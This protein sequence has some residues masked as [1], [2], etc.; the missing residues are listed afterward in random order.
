MRLPV[1]RAKLLASNCASGFAFDVYA[2]VSAKTL[3]GADH[4][5]EV[6]DSGAAAFGELSLGV[7]LDRVEVL[8]EVHGYIQLVYIT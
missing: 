4:L 2:D 8:A 6:A 1:V 5:A 7:W 3:A